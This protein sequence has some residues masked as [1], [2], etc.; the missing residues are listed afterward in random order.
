MK[1]RMHNKRRLKEQRKKK[2]IKKKERSPFSIA[3]IFY[4]YPFQF[5]QMANSKDFKWSSAV[6]A[7]WSRALLHSTGNPRFKSRAQI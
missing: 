5:N 6:V 4:V 2:L 1:E 7:E 3:I